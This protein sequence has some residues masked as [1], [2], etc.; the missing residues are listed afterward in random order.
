MRWRF[1]HA[2]NNDFTFVCVNDRRGHMYILDK[3]DEKTTNLDRVILKGVQN[4]VESAELTGYVAYVYFTYV[5][6]H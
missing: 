2:L 3:S 4:K 5:P 6:H 1:F